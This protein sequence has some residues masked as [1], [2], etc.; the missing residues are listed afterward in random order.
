[1]MNEQHQ[2]TIHSNNNN[3]NN[4]PASHRSKASLVAAIV[5]DDEEEAFKPSMF[6]DSESSLAASRSQ[7]HAEKQSE[8]R[9]R[10]LSMRTQAAMQV[11]LSLR[12]Q[13]EHA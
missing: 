12:R 2:N 3:N 9:S 7:L 5:V 13:P 1:M 4:K 11:D 6:G 10:F 8:S